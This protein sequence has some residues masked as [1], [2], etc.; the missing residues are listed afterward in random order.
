MRIYQIDNNYQIPT[1]Y[2]LSW[3]MMAASRHRTQLAEPATVYLTRGINRNGLLIN[4]RNIDIGIDLTF[5]SGNRLF[6]VDK[7]FISETIL[8]T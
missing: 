3:N 4:T 8:F 2:D 5:L 1:E 7:T 6:L